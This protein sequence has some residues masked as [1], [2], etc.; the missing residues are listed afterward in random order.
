MRIKATE[1]EAPGEQDGQELPVI[2]F[3]GTSHSM[4]AH[5]DPNAN[6]RIRGTVRLTKEGEVRW[7]SFSIYFGEE[8]WRSEGIQVGGVGSARGVFGHWFDKDFSLHGPAGP[9]ALWKISDVYD[10]EKGESLLNF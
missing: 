5:R 2:H 8:R 9:T 10:E 6:S 3:A 4:H 7:T 1:A